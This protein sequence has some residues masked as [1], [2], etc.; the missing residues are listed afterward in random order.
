MKRFLASKNVISVKKDGEVYLMVRI[1]L[2][3]AAEL[4][5]DLFYN[6][7]NHFLISK[8][9]VIRNQATHQALTVVLKKIGVK[10][11]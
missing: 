11:N 3:A 5:D 9:A 4:D 6:V 1:E 10:L 8:L 2:L 7:Y